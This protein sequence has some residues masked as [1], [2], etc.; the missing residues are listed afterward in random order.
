M[1]YH[2]IR[3]KVAVNLFLNHALLFWLNSLVQDRSL[4]WQIFELVEG[5]QMLVM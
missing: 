5:K 3:D 4:N 2:S 1:L